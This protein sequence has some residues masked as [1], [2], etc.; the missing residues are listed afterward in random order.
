L[1]AVSAARS[2]S[3]TDSIT[4]SLPRLRGRISTRIAARE[5][6]SKR[7][8]VDYISAR[9]AEQ[10]VNRMV[11]QLVTG[12]LAKMPETLRTVFTQGKSRLSMRLVSRSTDDRLHVSLLPKDKSLGD[13]MPMPPTIQSNA[14]VV[15]QI[16][17]PLLNRA[18]GR[19]GWKDA[20]R[21]VLAKTAKARLVQLVSTRGSTAP[22]WTLRWSGDHRWVTFTWSDQPVSRV[23]EDKVASSP[24]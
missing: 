1:P 15:V 4:S 2:Q 9:H 10:R 17:A 21:Q 7:G 18:L 16:H 5:V 11:D 20:V 12:A 6:A 8:Q 24:Y 13:E 23:V 3:V 19:A 14:D 22:H